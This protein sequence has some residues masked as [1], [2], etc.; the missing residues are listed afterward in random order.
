MSSC[1]EQVTWRL[2]GRRVPVRAQ[3][4]PQKEVA[5][6][7]GHEQVLPRDW[8]D[9]EYRSELKLPTCHR[10]GVGHL[11]FLPRRVE[12]RVGGENP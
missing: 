3:R 6:T 4:P 12:L 11:G 1:V 10:T 2:A 5:G 7:C 9:D 8:Q